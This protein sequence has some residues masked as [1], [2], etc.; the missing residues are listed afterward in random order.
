V[1]WILIV[2]IMCN[3]IY[4]LWHNY[5][6]GSGS[7]RPQ[8]PN[9][10]RTV[11]SQSP[12]VLIGE[13]PPPGEASSLQ[14]VANSAAAS[15]EPIVDQPVCWLV[16]P[17]KEVVSGRQAIGRAEALGHALRLTSLA[18]P[19]RPDYWV[20]LAPQVSRRTAIK[21]LREL[22]AKKIDSFLITKG[23][24]ENGISL[25]F[26]TRQDLAEKVYRERVGQGYD[27][28]IKEVPRTLTQIWTVYDTSEQGVFTDELWGKIREGNDDL[29][30]RK[31][32]CDKIASTDDLD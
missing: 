27:A 8:L 29:E 20:H 7:V 15:V 25:G 31:N 10:Q 22:Q 5:M 6:L 16:G 26:F 28:I 11:E 19:G 12:I 17:F 24:L 14:I 2:L 32:Y 9:Y 30:R 13:A 21:L 1:R 18:V 3:G 4:F 23:E